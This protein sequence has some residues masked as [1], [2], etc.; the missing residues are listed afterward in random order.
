MAYDFSK[1]KDYIDS[2][3]SEKGLPCGDV[4]VYLNGEKVYRYSV[5]TAKSDTIYWLFSCTKPITATAGMQLVEKGIINL[6]DPVSKY[7]PEYGKAVYK[8][9]NSLL[10]VGD[11]MKIRHLF[12]MSAGLNYDVEAEAIRKVK[13]KN[14]NASTIEIVSSFANSPLEFEPGKKF[15]YSL[16][17]DA[18]A[19]VIEKASGMT[20]GE[21]LQKNIFEPLGMTEATLHLPKE[22]ESRQAPS[23]SARNGVLFPFPQGIINY[24]I[25]PKYESGGAGLTCTLED[26]G[27]FAAAM[28]LGGISK[29]GVRILKSE[30]VDLLRSPQYTEKQEFGCPAGRGYAYGYGVRTL[31]TN[32]FGERSRIGEF[33]WDGAAGAFILMDPDAKVGIVYAQQIVGWPT[34]FGSMHA[35]MRDLTYE[36]LGL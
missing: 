20:F 4:I 1:L 34:H 9:G 15:R 18:L 31:I 36:A 5:G 13:E 12:T 17:L 33:G 16:C 24:A 35:P 29:D 14:P 30:T 11:K 7:F 2:L 19:G 6:D 8:E 23:F 27:K 32:E 21:Y 25:T 26:Y 28:S 22:K 3:Q 10:P